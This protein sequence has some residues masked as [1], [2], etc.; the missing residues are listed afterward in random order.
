MRTQLLLFALFFTSLNLSAQQIENSN[1]EIWVFDDNSGRKKPS[2][3]WMASTSCFNPEEVCSGFILKDDQGKTGAGARIIGRGLLK[4]NAPFSAKPSKISFWYKGNGG[5]IDVNVLSL[6][7]YEAVN[8]S[9]IIGHGSSFLVDAGSFTN[10][11]LPLTYDNLEE[12]KSI[13]IEFAGQNNSDFSF[14]ELELIYEVNAITDIKIAEILGSN[15]VTSSLILKNNV[16]ELSVYNTFG[17]RLLSATQVRAIDIT[18]L[19]EGLYI[20]VLR[21]DNFIGT[22]KVIKN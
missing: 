12:A 18:N 4:Y 21:K 13:Q 5:K 11:E 14:D 10:I 15:I 16:D 22:I 19:P 1:F 8:P 3:N 17:K 9:D 6:E 7:T 2:G 20:V